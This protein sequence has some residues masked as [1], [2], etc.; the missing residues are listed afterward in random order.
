[1]T[2]AKEVHNAV[3]FFTKT[4]ALRYSET[5]HANTA[6]T[7]CCSARINA[8]ERVTSTQVGYKTAA[9]QMSG[10]VESGQIG[11]E[12]IGMHKEVSLAGDTKSMTQ[13]AREILRSAGEPFVKEVEEVSKSPEPST[14][15]PQMRGRRQQCGCQTDSATTNISQP[16]EKPQFTP[17]V[18]EGFLDNFHPRFD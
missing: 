10:I 2:R 18:F 11:I 16:K 1:M 5:E 8:K 3:D 9:S 12:L 13:E 17:E 14:P 4:L 6:A 15:N 7:I